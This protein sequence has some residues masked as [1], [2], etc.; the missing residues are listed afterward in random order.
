MF[1]EIQQRY[2]N[3][4]YPKYNKCFPKYNKCYPKYNKCFPKVQQLFPE[5][6]TNGSRKYNKC[7]PKYNKCFPKVYPFNDNDAILKMLSVYFCRKVKVNSESSSKNCAIFTSIIYSY[8][9]P[10]KSLPLILVPFNF[11]SPPSPSIKLPLINSGSIFYKLL[12]PNR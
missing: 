8:L 2:H 6:T 11:V 5:S 1:P 10:L 3:K 9:I 12:P 7:F 4:C